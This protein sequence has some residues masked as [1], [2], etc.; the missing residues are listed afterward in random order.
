MLRKGTEW[1]GRVRCFS[2]KGA[3]VCCTL[4]AR[5]EESYRDPWFILTDLP[6]E[7]AEVCWYGLRS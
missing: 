5:W 2:S 6:V 1:G 7:Q 4:L 3:R